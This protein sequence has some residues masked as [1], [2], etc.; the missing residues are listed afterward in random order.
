MAR[1]NDPPCPRSGWRGGPREE[2]WWGLPIPED[3]SAMR[4]MVPLAMKL[5]FTGGIWG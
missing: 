3:P 2:R 5:R 4:R 1:V